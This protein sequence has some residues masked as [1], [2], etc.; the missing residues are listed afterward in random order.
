MIWTYLWVGTR[1]KEGGTELP[2]KGG[3]IM[4]IVQCP[5]CPPS[6]GNYSYPKLNFDAFQTPFSILNLRVF[7]ARLLKNK[8]VENRG[9]W[10]NTHEVKT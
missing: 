2:S 6:I 4:S 9:N 7:L 3:V 1:S 10:N 5:P 8:K